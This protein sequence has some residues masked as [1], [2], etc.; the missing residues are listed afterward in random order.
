M[1]LH[2]ALRWQQQK[3]NQTLNS[4]KTPHSSPSRVSCEVSIMRTFQENWPHYNGTAL[5]CHCHTSELSDS[6]VIHMYLVFR[7]DLP[8][9]DCLSG[10]GWLLMWPLLTTPASVI[11]EYSAN[12]EY[13]IM[14]CHN[15]CACHQVQRCPGNKCFCEYQTCPEISS[16]FCFV[17]VVPATWW[18]W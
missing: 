7:S 3:L 15:G 14:W 12:H 1:I 11:H 2:T 16:H 18:I 17:S 10:N 6:W 9:I 8:F 4:Q 13:S 5:Y